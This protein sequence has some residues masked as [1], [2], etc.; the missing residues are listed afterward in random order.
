MCFMEKHGGSHIRT[1]DTCLQAKTLKRSLV[2]V[3]VPVFLDREDLLPVSIGNRTSLAIWTKR[4]I[5][6][7]FLLASEKSVGYIFVNFLTLNKWID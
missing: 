7:T 1:H 6:M 3:P 5:P 2:L 4:M